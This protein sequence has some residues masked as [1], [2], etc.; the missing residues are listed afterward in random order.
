M[1]V[2]TV[3]LIRH[4]ETDGNLEKRYIG[5][6]TDESLSEDGIK[7][8]SNRRVELKTLLKDAGYLPD[9]SKD[10]S[11]DYLC[12]SI[13]SSPMK[14][15]LESAEILLMAKNPVVKDELKEI[16]FG[17]FEG[18]NYKELNGNEDYQNWIDSGGKLPFPNG[19]S[20]DAFI[21]RSYKAF[22][23]I[24]NEKKVVYS[25]SLKLNDIKSNSP[26]FI[27]CH[28]GNIMSI[29]SKLTGKNYF[30]FQTECGDGFEVT[31]KQSETGDIDE[32]SYHRIFGRTAT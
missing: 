28:G 19:E 30:D 2:K 23:E 11:V 5:K 16:D 32:V 26:I 7:N 29:M 27:I 24:I 3:Y 25:D 4:G 6:K 8:L 22:L 10:D 18:K 20:R 9:N 1:H 15:C 21:E 13:Y 12:F 17:D 31:I 14:R